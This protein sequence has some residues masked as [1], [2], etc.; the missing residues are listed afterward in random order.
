MPTLKWFAHDD[1]IKRLVQMR[2][3]DSNSVQ[4]KVLEI[5]GSSTVTMSKSIAGAIDDLC[6][7]KGGIS[8]INETIKQYNSILIFEIEF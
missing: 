6:G 2:L 4:S 3:E 5:R 1:N 8:M 7:I